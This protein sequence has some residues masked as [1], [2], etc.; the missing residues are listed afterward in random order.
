[1]NNF[2]QRIISILLYTLPLKAALPYGYA[3]FYKFDFLKIYLILTK[4]IAL[5][6]TS[7]PFGNLFLFLIIFL[8][9]VRNLNVPYFLRFNACQAL[10]LNIAIIIFG[11]LIQILPLPQLSYLVF[12][13]S[14]A[15]TIFSI[16]LCTIGI[17]P[18][19]PFISKSV[20]MQM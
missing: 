7:L 16:S 11:F 20:R 15:I 17:E 12:L 4:P 3:L 18:E 13:C 6:E 14:L 5:L 8:G 1:M 9:I 2:I 10:L 19:I